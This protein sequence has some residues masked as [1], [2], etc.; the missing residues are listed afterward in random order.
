MLLRKHIC[1]ALTPEVA[2]RPEEFNKN[3]LLVS[4]ILATGKELMKA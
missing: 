2:F 4:E 3:N 1:L